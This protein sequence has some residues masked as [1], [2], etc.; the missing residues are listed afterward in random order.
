MIALGFS[1]HRILMPGDPSPITLAAG[2]WALA[3]Q[4]T[5]PFVEVAADGRAAVVTWGHV[6]EVPEGCA[7]QVTNKSFHEGDAVFVRC[8]GSPPRPPSAITLQAGWRLEGDEEDGTWITRQVD[9]RT[10][11]RVYLWIASL[12]TSGSVQWTR[13]HRAF[14]IGRPN[15]DL[16]LAALAN[17]GVVIEGVT[18]ATFHAPLP[19]GIGS[20]QH[21]DTAAPGRTLQAVCP[22]ALR[23]TVQVS[24]PA[25]DLA[26]VGFEE[27]EGS[28]IYADSFFVVE[29]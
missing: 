15:W 22:H 1:V 7:A 20:G 27:E 25:A 10:A 18:T 28:G 14:E 3:T 13:T 12:S 9:V 21:L 29:Y 4:S 19:C 23:D 5:L 17:N 11:R 16:S 24:A 2:R 26:A 6:V 8:D